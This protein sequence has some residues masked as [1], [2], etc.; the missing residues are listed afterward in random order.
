MQRR[1][2][3]EE[4]RQRVVGRI[5]A[6]ARTTLAGITTPSA[7]SGRTAEGSTSHVMDMYSQPPL[8]PLHCARQDV[9][10]TPLS[11]PSNGNCNCR[12]TELGV[13]A[14][15]SGIPFSCAEEEELPA[16]I[17]STPNGEDSSKYCFLKGET[18]TGRGAR[19]RAGQ[20]SFA[21]TSHRQPRLTRQ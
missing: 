3:Q 17:L 20:V 15:V 2:Q 12:A 4:R 18:H 7:P 19:L 1:A 8:L 21:A 16:P 6:R 11:G 9:C 14:S 10:Y 5:V 13:K